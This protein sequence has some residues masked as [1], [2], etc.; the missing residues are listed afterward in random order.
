[1]ARMPIVATARSRAVQV[2]DLVCQSEAAPLLGNGSFLQDKL[3][4][5][6]AVSMYDNQPKQCKAC[7]GKSSEFRPS[8]Y[9]VWSYKRDEE[10]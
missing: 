6:M 7:Q 9:R 10:I 8:Q 3:Q 4:G 1:M 5:F 2:H